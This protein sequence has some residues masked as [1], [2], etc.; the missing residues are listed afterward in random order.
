MIDQSCVEL[1][2]HFYFLILKRDQSL[3]NIKLIHDNLAHAFDQNQDIDPLP[4]FKQPLILI[5]FDA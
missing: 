4:Q 2:N 3:I 5:T 1:H